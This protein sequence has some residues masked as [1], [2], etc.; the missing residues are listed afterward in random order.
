MGALLAGST[1]SEWTA[2]RGSGRLAADLRDELLR[3]MRAGDF[4]DGRLPPEAQLA[5][6][7]GVSRHSVRAALQSLADDGIVTR[8]RRHGTVI[9]ER[10]LRGSVPLNRF[11]SFRDLV[12]ESGF[13]CTTQPLRR[14]LVVPPEEVA[15]AIGLAPDTP[16]LVVERLLL[17][18]GRGPVGHR[19]DVHVPGR[20][21]DG[22]GRPLDARGPPAGGERRRPRAPGPPAGDAVR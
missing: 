14:E 12:E 16:C 11:A 19:V 5:Q 10:V 3:A 2:R 13:A 4:P 15:E 20:E 8:R 9:N 22:V 7:L 21:H 17:D 18:P 1:S 6:D